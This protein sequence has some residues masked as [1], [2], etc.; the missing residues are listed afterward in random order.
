[1]RGSLIAAPSYGLAARTRRNKQLSNPATYLKAVDA[2][3]IVNPLLTELTPRA[4]D[5]LAELMQKE[6]SCLKRAT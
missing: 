6:K 1:M 2:G 3:G 5:T 4:S